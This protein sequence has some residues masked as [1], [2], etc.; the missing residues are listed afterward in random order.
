MTT[1]SQISFDKHALAG[2]LSHF[3]PTGY[4]NSYPRGFG[5]LKKLSTAI[6]SYL[7][8]LQMDKALQHPKTYLIILL[9]TLYP[10]ENKNSI[11]KT[12]HPKCQPSNLTCRALGYHRFTTWSAGYFQ[13]RV[14]ETISLC[15]SHQHALRSGACSFLILCQ[16]LSI[17]LSFWNHR[18]L[19]SQSPINQG[20]RPRPE[21]HV[22][23]SF[24]L[25]VWSLAFWNQVCHPL[26][27][28]NAAVVEPSGVFNKWLTLSA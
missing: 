20:Q 7:S 15:S 1:P 19:E 23:S 17:H 28:A 9:C 26:H 13:S 10:W 12:S 2:F 6:S 3:S 21:T 24:T 25:Y 27:T 4:K 14:H 8:I 18:P 5:S 22:S 16:L 11:C